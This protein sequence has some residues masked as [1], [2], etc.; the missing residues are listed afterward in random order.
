VAAYDPAD[1]AMAFCG[2]GPAS[3]DAIG[4]YHFALSAHGLPVFDSAAA[5]LAC[6]VVEEA[7]AQGDHAIFICRLLDSGLREPVRR[8]LALRDTAW[9]YGGLSVSAERRL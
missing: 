8:S 9:H 7:N 5:W 2:A 3:P 6:E 1:F 4:G